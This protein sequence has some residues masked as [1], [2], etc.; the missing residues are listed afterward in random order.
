MSAAEKE[1]ESSIAFALG[2]AT[3]VGFLGF[4]LGRLATTAKIVV[5]APVV[6]DQ[7]R[8]TCDEV[9]PTKKAEVL[10]AMRVVDLQVVLRNRGLPVS[11]LKAELVSRV[12][13]EG[14]RPLPSEECFGA[15]R[16]AS[17]KSKQRM[18][19][20]AVESEEAADVWIANVLRPEIQATEAPG[21]RL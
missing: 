11:G 1:E 18:P 21:G 2:V 10:A 14:P 17:R 4:V 5:E 9:R 16:N 13:E 19:P 12:Q 20:Q 15:L 6:K 8:R 7:G 3:V